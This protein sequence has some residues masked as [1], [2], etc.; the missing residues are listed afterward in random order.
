MFYIEYIGHDREV[1]KI[2]KNRREKFELRRQIL[3][4]ENKGSEG[5][6]KNLIS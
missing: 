2:A 5:S 6:L 1:D 4:D 3:W